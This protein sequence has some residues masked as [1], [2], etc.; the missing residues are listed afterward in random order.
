MGRKNFRT[1]QLRRDRFRRSTSRMAEQPD[2]KMQHANI[3][4]EHWEWLHRTCNMQWKKQ[5]KLTCWK[6]GLVFWEVTREENRAAQ[7]QKHSVW[8]GM[9]NREWRQWCPRRCVL[10]GQ[11][12]DDGENNCKCIS[13]Q[14][15]E[16]FW[17][18]ETALN[19][20]QFS[21]GRFMMEGAECSKA[22]YDAMQKNAKMKE[23]KAKRKIRSI[24]IK[25][26]VIW[27]LVSAWKE[28]FHLRG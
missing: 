21:P 25:L 16:K 4:E 12:S 19:F 14:E 18:Y 13:D 6:M 17:I 5:K 15:R 24:H 3:R 7:I 20:T 9:G 8:M 23:K 1:E 26:Q 2:C 22:Y 11:T 28:R 10:R 27:V